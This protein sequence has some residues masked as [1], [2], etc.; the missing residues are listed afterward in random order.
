VVSGRSRLAYL[1][2]NDA[3]SIYDFR[4]GSIVNVMTPQ[5][6]GASEALR[7]V[8]GG[9]PAGLLFPQWSPSGAD[10]A[11]IVGLPR[12]G[13]APVVVTTGGALVG[14]GEVA[15][16]GPPDMAW[17][18]GSDELLYAV[19]PPEGGFYP[20]GNPKGGFPPSQLVSTLSIMRAPGWSPLR[21]SR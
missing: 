11:A 18:S 12:A 21:C 15:P 8:T 10:L 17:R 20:E 7:N 19:G 9:R 16:L 2:P 5:A 1:D 14:V 13:Y 6:V 3:L 4:S